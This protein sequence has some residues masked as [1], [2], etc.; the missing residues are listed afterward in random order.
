MSKTNKP[1]SEKEVFE[2]MREYSKK[3][4]YSFSDTQL[5]F[6]AENCFLLYESKG[7]CNVK[8]WPALAMKWVLNEARPKSYAEIGKFNKGTTSYKK[9]KLQG[10]SIRQ[11]I[12]ESE[13]E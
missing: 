4:G 3:K 13:N 11:K 12:M 8:Y 7:W 2:V 10:K 5:R 1:N 6:Y 9:P